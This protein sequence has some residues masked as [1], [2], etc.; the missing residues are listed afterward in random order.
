M[1]DD[2]R[3]SSSPLPSVVE[4]LPIAVRSVGSSG[5]CAV[6]DADAL[7]REV[8][9]RARLDAKRS[10]WITVSRNRTAC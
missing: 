4:K 7:P 9:V 1:N 2:L 8:G 10:R 6:D 5:E 3:H